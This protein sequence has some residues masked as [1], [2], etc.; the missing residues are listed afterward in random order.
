MNPD[1]NS[2]LDSPPQFRPWSPTGQ[3]GERRRNVQVNNGLSDQGHS[4]SFMPSGYRQ[5][6]REASEVSVEALD[7][8][9]YARTLRTRQ[10]G[11]HY[12]PFP[13]SIVEPKPHYPPSASLYIP[14]P[15][16]SRTSIAIHPPSLVSQGQTSSSPQITPSSAPSHSRRTA[17][18]PYSL[19]PT[20]NNSSQRNGSARGG[21][22]R[23]R[24]D[25]DPYIVDTDGYPSPDEIDIS[26]FPKWSRGWYDLNNSHVAA[27]PDDVYTPIPPSLFG[28]PKNKTTF[29]P[30]YTYHPYSPYDVPPPFSPEPSRNLLPWSSDPPE[31]GP[32]LNPILKEERIRMLEREFGKN[33]DTDIFDDD[34]KPKVGSVDE[35]GNLVTSGPK[36]RILF[37]VLEIILAVGA[38]VPAIYAS[39]VGDYSYFLSYI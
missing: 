20:P 33:K 6:R 15:G 23:N 3:D 1:P 16:T 17:P 19:P 38:C 25:Q 39:L 36:R 35:K 34:V 9:D 14:Q 18:R 8:A 10:A 4:R 27:Q 13:S 11:D 7:L 31:Y 29:D 32:A 12:P 5:Q 22:N 21:L 26:R 37:R 2:E 30:G 24:Q 28:S